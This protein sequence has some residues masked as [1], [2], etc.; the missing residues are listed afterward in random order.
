MIG[1]RLSE[2]PTNADWNRGSNSLSVRSV[3]V[4][5]EVSVI[6]VSSERRI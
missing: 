1:E 4:I 3:P 2:D 5:T 6:G